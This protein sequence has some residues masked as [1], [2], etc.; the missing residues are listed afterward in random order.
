MRSN[1]RV[2]DGVGGFKVWAIGSSGLTVSFNPII[3]FRYSFVMK[4]SCIMPKEVLEVKRASGDL[5]A[6]V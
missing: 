4:N 5:S 2:K 6:F 3:L 1:P